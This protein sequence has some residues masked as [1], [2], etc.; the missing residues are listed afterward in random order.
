MNIDEVEN[1]FKYHSPKGNQAERYEKL[2]SFALTMAQLIDS[3]CPDS[4]EKDVAF[5]KLD[6]V[7]MFA[8]AAIARNE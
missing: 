7:I 8:N 5:T 6:E 1:R 2:R 4:R 3:H